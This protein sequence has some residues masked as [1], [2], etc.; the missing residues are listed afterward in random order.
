ME[1]SHLHALLLQ[2]SPCNELWS[3][4]LASQTH[5][6]PAF[7]KPPAQGKALPARGWHIPLLC[8][9][10]RG[11]SQ[12]QPRP[13]A[14]CHPQGTGAPGTGFPR[15]PC[16]AHPGILRGIR[17]SEGTRHQQ[18]LQGGMGSREGGGMGQGTLSP[19]PG[20]AGSF[21]SISGVKWSNPTPQIPQLLPAHVGAA[22]QIL[23]HPT[24]LFPG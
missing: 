5:I 2:D 11:G 3:R 9:L 22:A 1:P 13:G 19:P 20:L 16:S 14:V 23:L 6:L 15:C 17:D 18:H 8:L 7:P 21:I 24:R 10:S 4:D 12:G